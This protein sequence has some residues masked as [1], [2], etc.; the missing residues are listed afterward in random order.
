MPEI[1]EITIEIA[2]R[3]ETVYRFLSDADRFRQWVGD[4]DVA[5]FVGGELAVRYPNGDIARGKFVEMVPN[6]RIVFTWGYDN[7][8]DGMAPGSS[9]VTI[10]LKDSGSGTL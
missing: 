3:R 2:A 1:I 4:A 6:E 10:E 7:S 9:T 5:P 8:A